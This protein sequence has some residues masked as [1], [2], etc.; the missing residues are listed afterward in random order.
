[1]SIG[2]LYEYFRNRDAVIG[3]LMDRHI[4]E[5]EADLL[6]ALDPEDPR[7]G[8]LETGVRSVIDRLIA[9]HADHPTLHRLL[10]GI[11]MRS[12]PIRRRI[13]EAE[14]HLCQRLEP[15]LRAHPDVRHPDPRLAARIMVQGSNALV[16]RHVEDPGPVT[17]EQLATELTRLW[18]AYLR[19]DEPGGST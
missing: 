11:G 4:H 15:W 1:M 6:D 10:V 14:D 9:Q 2:S 12:D 3:A 8:S 7:A 5:A 19:G 13:Q 18:V 16:H 17:N